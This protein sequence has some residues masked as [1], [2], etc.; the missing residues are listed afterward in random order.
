MP[1]KHQV[2]IIGGGF[3]GL[4]AAK[5]LKRAP[6]DVT[7]IDKRNFHLFQPLLYQIA[8]GSLS[9]GEIAAPIRGVLNQNKNTRVLMGEAVDLN[10]TARQVE[11]K[12]GSL[13]PYD[14]L[15]V[16][17]GSQ[18]SFFGH[19]EW[20]EWAPGLKTVED[21][22]TIRHKILLAFE[23][24]EREPDPDERH[25]WLTFVIVGAGATG[26]ELAGALGEIAHH[27]LKDDFRMI[28]PSDATIIVVDGGSRALS[29][30][31]ED[32]SARAKTS[33]EKLGVTLKFNLMVTN[34]DESGVTVKAK[35]GTEDHI[36]SH[37]VL[38]AA[39]VTVSDFGKQVAKQTNAPTKK[40]GLIEVKPDLTIP[41]YPN[42]FVVGDLAY[43]LDRKGQP[44]PGVAQVAMQGGTYAAK[45]IRKR[46][47]GKSDVKPFS[48][49]DKG[50]LAVI[51]RGRAVAEVFG[52]HLSGLIAWLVWVFIH[53]LYVVEFQSRIVVFIE[54]GFLYLTYSR[55]ARLITWQTATDQLEEHQPV[56]GEPVVQ[57]P[58]AATT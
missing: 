1:D 30:F 10:P 33:L 29:S 35:D 23:A 50:N 17:T 43:S 18:T 45:T 39:G 8:T 6:V 52:I 42:I 19:K 13:I 3:G 48:Y 28:R 24:A 57:K 14:T 27:T 56:V 38:W 31:P 25:A 55:G 51:G 5:A 49:F 15:I 32:L 9:P 54:W 36:R 22:T 41:G 4:D 16:A 40:G 58:S 20:S 21:A 46:L 26:V 7:V 37:T 12:D 2:V 53:L 47:E 11:L 34:V 44:L